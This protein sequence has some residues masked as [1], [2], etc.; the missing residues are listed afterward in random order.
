MAQ[1]IIYNYNYNSTVDLFNT[2]VVRDH[3]SISTFD[4]GK[5]KWSTIGMEYLYNRFWSAIR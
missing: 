5:S 4:Q 3:L 1:M 2:H